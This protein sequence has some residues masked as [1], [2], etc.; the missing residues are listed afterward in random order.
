MMVRTNLT[1]TQFFHEMKYILSYNFM[2]KSALLVTC[3][4]KCIRSSYSLPKLQFILLNTY[5]VPLLTIIYYI[6]RHYRPII[7]STPTTSLLSI[8]IA[9][10]NRSTGCII[11]FPYTVSCYNG[12][13]L[14]C[15][16]SLTWSPMSHFLLHTQVQWSASGAKKALEC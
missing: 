12:N 13:N 14:F 15:F 3:T 4:L 5:T 16:L 7:R 11:C 10:T 1:K 6:L 9:E 2:W 8:G